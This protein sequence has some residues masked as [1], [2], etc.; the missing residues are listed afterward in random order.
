M[1]T[2]S[3]DD[4]V[5]LLDRTTDRDGWLTPMLE[6]A[7]GSAA[8]GA[9]IEQFVRMGR[10]MDYT[11]LVGF[12]S[13]APGG[14][15]GTSVV[16]MSRPSSG[17]SG[18]IPVGYRFIDDRGVVAVVATPVAVASG[19]L[20]AQIPVETLRQTEAVNTDDDST[21]AVVPDAGV[22]LDS[23]GTTALLAPVGNP[24]IV[25]TTLQTVTA[26]TLILGGASDWLAIHGKE[27][28]QIRQAGEDTDSYRARV[29]NIPDAVSPRAI[30]QAIQAAASRGGLPLFQVLEPFPDLASASVK[31][32]L[33]LGSFAPFYLDDAVEGFAGD[34]LAEL[35][36]RR[37]ATAY[38][39]VS[40][41]A[42]LVDPALDGMFLDF[43]FLDDPDL[44]F[45]DTGTDPNVNS[46]LMSLWTDVN[47]K[48]AA[49]VA[50]DVFTQEA[51]REV[52]A[53][54]SSS[55]SDTVVWTLTPGAGKTWLYVDGYFGHGFNSAPLPT[56]LPFP[57]SLHKI[58]FTFDDA[59]T[60][61]TVAFSFLWEERITLQNYVGQGIQQ[62]PITKVEGI[63]ASDGT[64][65]VNLVGVL[66]VVEL[67]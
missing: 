1:A 53:G 66:F 40:A 16:T 11:S 58:R 60:F 46:A 39:R 13:S 45:L 35:V 27:R 3:H 64:H 28:G 31:D 22:V 37:D 32:P 26:T 12:I 2:F 42:P 34:Y 54:S 21:L 56:S 49:G 17:T 59:S 61:T 38:F 43:S 63:V 47:A 9:L 10:A 36:D 20:T 62:R 15:V 18:T 65:P 24:A 41:T 30:G 55:G 19:D 57:A 29:R 5:S 4:I 52:G 14:G 25:A 50:F 7:D 48:K 51:V 8:L 6:D 33:G 23:L 67:A 44:G